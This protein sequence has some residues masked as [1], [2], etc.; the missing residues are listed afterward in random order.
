MFVD[1]QGPPNCLGIYEYCDIS[2]GMWKTELFLNNDSLGC[3][4][5]NR[6]IFQGDSFSPLLFIVSLIPLSALLQRRQLGYKLGR[7][8][9]SSVLHGQSKALY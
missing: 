7:A 1:V 6:G 2:M 5:I 8:I 9:K 3:I 4:V